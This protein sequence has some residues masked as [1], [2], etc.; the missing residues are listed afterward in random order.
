M[1]N[2]KLIIEKIKLTKTDFNIC[3][4]G[5][6]L[7][8]SSVTGGKKMNKNIIKYNYKYYKRNYTNNR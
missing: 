5:I 4:I 6:Y 7:C 2:I 3:D 8:P 1:Q